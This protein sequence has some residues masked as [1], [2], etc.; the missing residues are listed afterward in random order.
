[1]PFYR[2]ID[3]DQENPAPNALGESVGKTINGCELR[4]VKVVSAKLIRR[5]EA[6]C[7]ERGYR[8]V[9]C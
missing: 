8:N 5:A 2:I 9:G 1:V 7:M 4:A 6:A 3:R